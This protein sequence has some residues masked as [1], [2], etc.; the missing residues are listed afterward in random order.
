MFLRLPDGRKATLAYLEKL[1]RFPRPWPTETESDRPLGRGF[2]LPLNP[3]VPQFPAGTQVALVRR[4][5]LF[6]AAGKLMGTAV[7]ESIQIRVYRQVPAGVP[8]AMRAQDF[9]EFVLS[10]ALL[11]AGETGGLRPVKPEETEFRIF[12]SHLECVNCH[13]QPGVHSL[14]SIESLFPPRPLN[15]DSVE[16]GPQFDPL[17][18]EVS[19]TIY[20][21]E[22]RYDWG[23]L[24]ALRPQPSG[25]PSR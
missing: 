25:P 14:R 9:F 7:T 15:A 2:P 5:V 10:R 24:N 19:S 18:G 22:N 6:D 1:W 4:M 23:L 8:L 21:K 17:S 12:T 3:E 13:A 11:L 16:S 20:W